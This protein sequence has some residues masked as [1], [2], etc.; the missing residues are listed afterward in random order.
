MTTAWG[1]PGGVDYGE[2]HGRAPAAT[3]AAPGPQAGL[4]ASATCWLC[5]TQLPTAVMVA[6]GGTA[7]SDV[8]W[9]CQDAQQC[10]WRWTT[11]SR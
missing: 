4:P 11:K 10:T 3:R 6:D 1:S 9:Y 5:G 8:R 7:C 2:G